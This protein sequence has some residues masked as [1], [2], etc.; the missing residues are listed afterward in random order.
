VKKVVAGLMCVCLVLLAGC[1]G[2]ADSKADAEQKEPLTRGKI[3]LAYKQSNFEIEKYVIYVEELNEPKST[4]SR[5]TYK[6]DGHFFNIYEFRSEED[7][8]AYTESR[9]RR[10]QNWVI[11]GYGE[12]VLELFAQ[13][14]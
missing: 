8:I 9:S 3:E 1:S 10:N 5:Y 6:I 13:I 2:N 4:K 7:A 14:K 12:A 11:V